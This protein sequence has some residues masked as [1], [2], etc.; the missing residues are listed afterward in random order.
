MSDPNPIYYRD[1]VRPDNSITDLIS[2]LQALIAEYEGARAKIQSTAS[3]MAKSMQ[4]VS[5]A[6]EDQ[7]EQI[8]STAK[9]AE[10]L[11]QEMTTLN[12]AQQRA[13]L[14]LKEASEIQREQNQLI[15]LR[16]QLARSEEGS[17]NR[18][19]AQ[20]RILK[21][22]INEMGE[23]DA[24]A[25]QKKR[26]L[27]RQ[28]K[29]LYSRMND[30][31]KATGKYT[32]QV[33]NYE[34]A[35]SAL[36]GPLNQVVS[37]FKDMSKQLSAISGSDMPRGT[38][39]LSMLTTAFAGLTAG[40]ILFF[41]A[42]GSSMK[43]ITNFEQSVTNLSTILG[44]TTEEM[45]MLR[46]SAL[47]L[48]RTTEYTASQVVGLQTELAKL[49][50]GPGSIVAMEKPI[51]QFATAVGADLS[52]AA[53]V[54]GATLRAFGLS[55][56]DTEEV[57]AT[58]AVATNKSAL[59]FDRI[60]TSMG[61][62]F[63]VANAFG[64][65]VKDTAA[66]LGALADAGFDASSAA[67]ATRNI[68]LNLANANGKLAKSLG[69]PVKSFDE[70]IDG[71]KEL[72]RRG[73]D[74]NTVLE[75]TDKRSVAAFSA[76][77]SG[78]EKTRELRD[79][80]QDVSGELDRIQ[81][82]RLNTVEGST[83][84]LKSAWEG[85]TL[86]FSNST[87]VM[88]SVVDWLTKMVTKTQELLFPTETLTAQWADKYTQM[89]KDAAKKGG[90]V[91]M[92]VANSAV[93]NARKELQQAQLDLANTASINAIKVA[94][95]AKRVEE[96]EAKLNGALKAQLTL[97]QSLEDIAPSGITTPTSPDGGGGG[98][99][100]AKVSPEET[101]EYWEK[102]AQAQADAYDK[103]AKA[104]WK[105]RMDAQKAEKAAYLE[106]L[107][108]EKKVIQLRIE[109]EAEGTDEMLRL[110]LAAINKERE[111]ELEKNRQAVAERRVDEALINAKYDKMR[112][113]EIAK[114]TKVATDIV[115]EEVKQ[116]KSRKSYGNLW[117][118]LIP[119]SDDPAVQDKIEGIREAVSQ[120]VAQIMEVASQLIGVWEEQAEKAVESANTQVEAAQK[121]V[122]AE[123]E[124]AAN[125][126]ANNVRR[127]EQELALAKKNQEKALREEE[128]AQKARLALESVTQAA[129]LV[130]ASA[131]I[132][133]SMSG[134]PIV[135]PALAITSIALMWGSFLASKI[136]A[137]QATKEAYGEGT[138][139]LLQGG[140]HASGND[141]SLGRKADGTERRAEG[142]E[143]FAV[144][145]RKNSRRY[146]TVIPD[147]IQSFNDGTF[148][149]K[150]QR[151]NATIAGSTIITDG[152]DLSR[153]ESGVDAI[154]RQGEN[155]RT[156]E[157]GKVVI[158]YKNLTRKVRY[159]N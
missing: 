121:V 64:L 92:D 58:L 96:A 51:L 32:L 157:G 68:I 87:G 31:Q 10:Q 117:D 18:L 102:V 28:A 143:F 104:E 158:R 36:P 60:Q 3:D 113:A 148:A 45:D 154:R 77:L 105:A 79:A 141:I 56:K 55:G 135:G 131:N 146:R 111:I 94:K 54:A 29:A 69:G 119:D 95:N 155:Q 14:K 23:A 125:G 74:L 19:S 50:F 65:S 88:K 89:F 47:Q 80:L 100:G 149:D 22:R 66:L 12:A 127:A 57:L 4:M 101:P 67:T 156:V 126:Y 124:A 75:L 136:K 53:S 2:Q 15:K 61:T 122:D 35:L 52:S 5:G 59:S 9:Q 151:A 43:T 103:K 37:G 108:F 137:S 17:Y 153:L 139:E 134:I 142:G 107:E 1:L 44:G 81:G 26:E 145:N 123:R 82:E 8:T 147:V 150:Y 20:Y 132:W 40:A 13:A 21:M 7:R 76:L 110:R 41:K 6:T 33:G 130:T 63:P 27:E 109:G 48:G 144:I 128:K 140:S 106:Q 83:K 115:E 70:M 49:G 24:K 118:V 116:A 138:V 93:T 62:V 38:K 71:L 85:L 90:D 73:I 133:S 152:A 78:T 46:E 39:A 30:L 84:L 112:Q 97:R 99:G 34:R 120:F 91:A 129:S 25:V 159:E 42:L 98:G 114:N 16:T 11:A 72:H 86:A